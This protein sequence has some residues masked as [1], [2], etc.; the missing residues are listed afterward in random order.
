MEK[1]YCNGPSEVEARLEYQNQIEELL[2][3]ASELD[4]KVRHISIERMEKDGGIPEQNKPQLNRELD[5][6]IRRYR[7]IIALIKN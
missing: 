6:V 7:G 5:E 3:M 2:A 4:R 1:E